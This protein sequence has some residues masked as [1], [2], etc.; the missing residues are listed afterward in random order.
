MTH[1]P[2][3]LIEQFVQI[4]NAYPDGVSAGALI[5]KSDKAAL[6]D[7]GLVTPKYGTDFKLTE[8]GVRVWGELRRIIGYTNPWTVKP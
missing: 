7:M 3:G 6:A 1:F 5:S 4:A 2:L 8:D